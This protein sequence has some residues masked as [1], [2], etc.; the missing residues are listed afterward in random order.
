[1]EPFFEANFGVSSNTD[2]KPG[3]CPNSASEGCHSPFGPLEAAPD[4]TDWLA[5]I[6]GPLEEMVA[7]Q[8]SKT[9]NIAPYIYS[10]IK[11][12]CNCKRSRCLK[13]YCECY[14]SGNYCNGCNCVNC[15]NLKKYDVS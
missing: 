15:L 9:G 5:S 13:L 4:K 2:E 3:K 6:V 12:G 8:D 7:S 10:G 1:M 11:R 14:A